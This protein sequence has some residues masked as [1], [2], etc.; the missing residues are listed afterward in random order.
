MGAKL[1]TIRLTFLAMTVGLLFT[2]CAP[3]APQVAAPAT[4]APLL[5]TSSPTRSPAVGL[6][7]F[8]S[9]SPQTPAA[10]PPKLYATILDANAAFARKDFSTALGLYREAAGDD[11][12][13][14]ASTSHPVPPGPELRAFARFRIVVA[15]SLVGQEDD[16]RATLEA[17]RQRD[18]G[19]AFLRL[20]QLF[21]DSYGMTADPRVACGQVTQQVKGDPE[22]VLR[23]LN[24]W[25]PT[26]PNLAPEDIC[27]IG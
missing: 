6:S 10:G 12:G 25:G 5:P 23:S 16:A 2:A 24:N 17:A 8:P 15:D 21:W 1:P 11:S 26:T 14:E 4:S 20:G 9:P 7:P 27:K 3:S 22:P 18:S 19:T 13:L